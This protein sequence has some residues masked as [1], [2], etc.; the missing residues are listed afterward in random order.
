[1]LP[2]KNRL[3]PSLTFCPGQS[4]TDG[5]PE[6]IIA[7]FSRE[8][9]KALQGRECAY[10]IFFMPGIEDKF[11]EVQQ[12]LCDQERENYLRRLGKQEGQRTVN[13]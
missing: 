10:P 4:L 11:L 3:T 7:M 9:A 13:P 5:F 6:K 2:N 8:K 1:M 12:P